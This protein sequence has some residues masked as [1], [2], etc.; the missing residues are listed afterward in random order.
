MVNELNDYSSKAFFIFSGIFK[1]LWHLFTIYLEWL[2]IFLKRNYN[3]VA[4]FILLFGFVRVFRSDIVPLIQ[5]IR[6]FDK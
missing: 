3:F 6:K 2:V 5:Y 1:L 4:M